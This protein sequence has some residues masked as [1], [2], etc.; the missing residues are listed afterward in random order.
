MVKI[1]IYV[2]EYLVMYNKKH[3]SPKHSCFK[4]QRLNGKYQIHEFHFNTEKEIT[5]FT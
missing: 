1:T 2:K 5:A 4:K 3:L